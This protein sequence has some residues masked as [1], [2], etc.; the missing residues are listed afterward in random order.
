MVRWQRGLQSFEGSAELEARD[1]F[2]LTYVLACGSL[3]FSY[4]TSHPPRSWFGLLIAQWTQGSHTTYVMANFQ[5]RRKKK[6]LGQL[7]LCLGLKEDYFLSY[8]SKLL[9]CSS[10]SKV[11]EQHTLSLDERL[12]SSHC[13][14]ACVMGDTVAVILR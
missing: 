10:N 4:V 6:L 2:S 9:Q 13:R 7:E 12:A 1:G 11:V 5:D 14:R 3:A 8:W